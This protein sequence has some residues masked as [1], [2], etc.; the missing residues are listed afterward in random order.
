MGQFC[1]K[2]STCNESD[3]YNIKRPQTIDEHVSNKVDLLGKIEE[4]NKIHPHTLNRQMKPGKN[5]EPNALRFLQFNILAEGLS[6]PPEFG[7]FLMSP[8]ESL[9]WHSFR[10]FRVLQ[11][12]LDHEADVICLE[13]LDHFDDFMKPALKSFGYD[14]IF[15]PKT[16]APTLKFGDDKFSDGCAIFWKSSVLKL[17]DQQSVLYQNPDPEGDSWSQVALLARMARTSGTDSFI[18]SAT[19]LK[20]KKGEKNEIR[21]TEQLKQLMIAL[22]SMQ[23]G[24]QT[25]GTE[26]EP[27][28]ILGDFNTDP[29]GRDEG[30]TAY[31]SVKT[32]SLGLKSAYATDCSTGGAIEEPLYTTC[33]VRAKG[34]SCHTIDYIWVPSSAR[35]L[36]LL[37]IPDYVSLPDA[38]LPSFQYPSDHLAIACDLVIPNV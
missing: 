16:D 23:K 30:L 8:K 18:V 28:L 32:S 24:S 13:E 3:D 5:T 29:T 33:K 26:K 27:V 14:G 22:S 20:S 7:G 10:K 31:E 4:L 37:E 36:N 12:I 1:T 6:S 38:K 25:G 15:Q 19:H 9:D 34:E 35:V 21:R 17:V 11:E 2:P